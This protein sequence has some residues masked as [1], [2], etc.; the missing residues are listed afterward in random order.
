MSDTYRRYGAIKR[1]IVQCYRLRPTGHR[2]RHF[3]T[4][5]AL[6]CGLVGGQRAHLSTI[7]DHAPS[8]GAD[9]ESLIMRFRRWLKH[10]GNTR[11]AWFLPI[12]HAVLTS[13]AQQQAPLVLVMDGSVVGRGGLA[14]MLSVVY[15]GRALPLAWVVISAKK[16]HFPQAVH[17]ALLAQVQA[18]LPPT[19]TV[20]FLGDGEF[21]GT[22]LQAALH[23]AGWQYVCRTA[24]NICFTAYG[25]R[26][27]VGDLEPVRG[28]ALAVT[29]AWMTTAAYG[30]ISLLAVWE[31]AYDAP[32]YLVT[33]M[34]N[35]EHAFQ[36]YRQRAQ[37]ETFFSDQ[38][39]RG[40]H[41]HKSQLRDPARLDRLLIASCLAYVWIVYLGVC[42]LRDDWLKR[43]HRQDRCDLSLFRLGLRLLARC[44]KDH[45]ALPAGLLPPAVLPKQPRR[46]WANSTC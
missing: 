30:P 17:C 31:V 41:L 20:V 10:A 9:Q 34:P 1:A 7:A 13:L 19:A 11:D 42:A 43:L 38:K 36:R 21:D 27:H 40:F 3:N 35:L 4:L 12:A 46:R 26:R 32:I 23:Q 45:I 44:L 15:Y 8:G 28:E 37:I 2:E 22:D 14:L 6:I 24:T 5:A 25:L 33:N 39:S 29:P 18:I 16:G